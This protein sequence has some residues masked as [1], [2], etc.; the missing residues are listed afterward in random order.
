MYWISYKWGNIK[1]FIELFCK[2]R[3]ICSSLGYAGR[4]IYQLPHWSSYASW[5]SILWHSF[6]MVSPLSSTVLVG[7]T[8]SSSKISVFLFLFSLVYLAVT[9]IN[10]ISA[11]DNLFFVSFRKARI[12]LSY[13]KRLAELIH[14]R[15]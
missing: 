14:F 9:L 4:S 10:L 5:W 8:S 2:S 7:S 13:N 3:T 11:A 12:S 15:L 6:N 1:F